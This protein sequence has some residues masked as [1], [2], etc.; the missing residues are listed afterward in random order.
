MDLQSTGAA[1]Q[2]TVVLEAAK[3]LAHRRAGD[4]EAFPQDTSRKGVAEA[5]APARISE[6]KLGVNRIP[7]CRIV[8][9]PGDTTFLPQW[10]LGREAYA[11]TWSRQFADPKPSPGHP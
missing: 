4:T 6:R 8:S 7:S 5:I 11:A 1:V 10:R 9:E 2:K 3:S